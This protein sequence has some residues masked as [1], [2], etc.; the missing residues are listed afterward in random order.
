VKV[1][2]KPKQIRFAQLV[3]AAGRPHAA[4]LWTS[5]PEADPEFKKAMEENRVVSI[6]A[7]HGGSKKDRGVIGF[8]E[9]PASYL[10]FPKALP[11]AEGTGVIGLKFEELEDVPVKDPVKVVA[12]MPAKKI[13]PVKVLEKPAAEPEEVEEEEAESKPKSKKKAAPREKK[14]AAPKAKEKKAEAV[15]A[16]F[17]VT[18]QFTA[19][20]S[21]DFEVEAA[22]ASAAI[23]AALKEAR[24]AGPG[25][26][27]WELEA[28]E[29]KKV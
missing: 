26:V 11:M 6:R 24:D 3:K 23:D 17:T 10:I 29:A 27:D 19:T 12:R 1:L 4:T 18:V 21:R 16:K 25:R 15:A 13:E 22:N 5:S 2:E 8:L 14:K 7:S 28:T 20:V 9:G